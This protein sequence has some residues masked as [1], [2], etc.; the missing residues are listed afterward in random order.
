V[1][2]RIE[3]RGRIMDIILVFDTDKL[4]GLKPTDIFDLLHA[5]IDKIKAIADSKMMN[6]VF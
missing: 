5:D 2:K 6:E 3:I 4:V 1:R